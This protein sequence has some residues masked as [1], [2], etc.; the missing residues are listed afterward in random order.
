MRSLGWNSCVLDFTRGQQHCNR[1]MS[2][3]LRNTSSPLRLYLG[4]VGI[5]RQQCEHIS[6]QIPEE[7]RGALDGP[8]HWECALPLESNDNHA[9]FMRQWA[10]GHDGRDGEKTTAEGQQHRSRPRTPRRLPNGTLTRTPSTEF[11]PTA[12]R[13]PLQVPRYLGKANS[14]AE[15]VLCSSPCDDVCVFMVGL[16]PGLAQ[17]LLP[18]V[19]HNT[20][21]AARAALQGPAAM[22]SVGPIRQQ[23][24]TLTACIRA[25]AWPINLASQ[26]KPHPS[27]IPTPNTQHPTPNNPPS[28]R[29]QP[30]A[31]T[32]TETTATSPP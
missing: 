15:S 7:E 16:Q 2:K 12:Q 24:R 27:P 13:Q 28:S 31:D 5:P 19:L 23:A 18:C 21:A 10:S 25:A 11:P 6:A 20:A 30:P 32:E 17:P 26:T 1:R 22:L 4:L 9:H 8:S 3:D 29:H 14:L